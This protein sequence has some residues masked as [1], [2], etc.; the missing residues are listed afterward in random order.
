MVDVAEELT[1]DELERAALLSAWKRR[2]P[3]DPVSAE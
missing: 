2:R 1:E 3:N